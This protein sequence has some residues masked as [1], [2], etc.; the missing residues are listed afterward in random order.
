M[1]IS[2]ENAFM[3]NLCRK[4]FCR[5]NEPASSSTDI[6][7]AEALWELR[8]YIPPLVTELNEKALADAGCQPLFAI[9]LFADADSEAVLEATL[10]SLREQVYERWHVIIIHKG[11]RP[12]SGAL[13]QEFA[14]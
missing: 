7:P 8:D 1:R 2:K 11:V 5:K 13:L 3:F 10:Q 4:H 9:L 12:A 14:S 6:A